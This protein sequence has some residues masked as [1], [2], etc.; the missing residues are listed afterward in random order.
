MN[1]KYNQKTK[2]PN[3]KEKVQSNQIK[4]KSIISLLFSPSLILTFSLFSKEEEGDRRNKRKEKKEEG[5]NGSKM[6]KVACDRHMYYI[7]TELTDE[8][9]LLTK[10][11]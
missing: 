1:K 2:K 10:V 11:R 3:R 4:S 8:R 7:S 5:K 9:G 6:L